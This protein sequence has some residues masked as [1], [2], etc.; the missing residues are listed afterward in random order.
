MQAK[1]RLRAKRSLQEKCSLRAECSPQSK[2][3]LQEEGRLGGRSL[4]P[5][6]DRLSFIM[7]QNMESRERK[8]L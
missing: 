2:R 7:R 4:R 3:S 8:R 5:K 6:R 1:R